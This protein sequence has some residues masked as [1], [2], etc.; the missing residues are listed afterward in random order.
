MFAN[1]FQ[2]LKF[3]IHQKSPHL[4]H[5]KLGRGCLAWNV[6]SL[7]TRSA[8]SKRPGREGSEEKVGSA[9]AKT[10]RGNDGWCAFDAAVGRPTGCFFEATAAAGGGRGFLRGWCFL[11][12][13]V[14]GCCSW[15]CWCCCCC[16]CCCRCL[17]A[18]RLSRNAR[19]ARPLRIAA[20]SPVATDI[21]LF[22]FSKKKKKSEV[23]LAFFSLSLLS[24]PLSL[25]LS[26]LLPFFLQRRALEGAFSCFFSL[27]ELRKNQCCFLQ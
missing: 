25:S 23:F 15:C 4:L 3:S 13:K 2:L 18:E 24:S 20:T 6:S 19:T 16:C 22:S 7:S 17:T 1:F 10:W 9:K 27:Q 12:T 8:P 5:S 26:L 21:F 11:S 14:A